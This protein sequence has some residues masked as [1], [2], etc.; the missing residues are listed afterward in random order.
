MW[1]SKVNLISNYVYRRLRG[2]IDRFRNHRH[3]AAAS[4]RS[5]YVN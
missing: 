1:G 5:T 4:D 3:Q 2:L